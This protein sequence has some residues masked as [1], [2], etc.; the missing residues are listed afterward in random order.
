MAGLLGVALVVALLASRRKMRA[1]GC[2]PNQPLRVQAR[3][4]LE[5]RAHVALIEAHG[6]TYLL[7][8][9]E[10]FAVLRR[11]G[12]VAPNPSGQEFKP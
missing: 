6:H 7:A 9:G 3:L 2:Q 11:S 1:R 10:G 8:Y 4:T 5:P 12:V